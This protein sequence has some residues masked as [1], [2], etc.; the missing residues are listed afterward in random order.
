MFATA[1]VL[2]ITNVEDE[3]SSNLA[4]HESKFV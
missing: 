4:S 3:S 1:S 2:Y